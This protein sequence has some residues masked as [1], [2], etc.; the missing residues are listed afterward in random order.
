[1]CQ[2]NEHD[3]Q[4]SQTDLQYDFT[5]MVIFCRKCGKIISDKTT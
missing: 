3:F 2:E 4:M 1:M 5:R